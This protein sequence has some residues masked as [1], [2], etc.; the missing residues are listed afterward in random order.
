[1]KILAETL[2]RLTI[3]PAQTFAGLTLYPLIG[4]EAPAPAYRTLDEALDKLTGD[5]LLKTLL[6]AYGMCYGVKPSEISFA[7]HSRVSYGLYEAV[8]RVEGGGEAFIRAFQERAAD[9]EIEIRPGTQIA[10][11]ADVRDRRIGRFVLDTGEDV[12][13]D[14]CIFTIHPHEVL[15]ILPRN[16]LSKA[17][18]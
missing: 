11:C 9:L 6:S 10:E 14:H 2:D 4:P 12:S 13:C 1:M 3:G 5:G 18:V 17:F 15:K 7:N 16:H 8:A